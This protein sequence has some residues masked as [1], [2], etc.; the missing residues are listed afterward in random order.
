MNAMATAQRKS[1]SNDLSPTFG[2]LGPAVEYMLDAAQRGV[3][4]WD[5]MRQNPKPMLPRAA[6]SY[7][8]NG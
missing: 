2:L 3:L 1:A 5:V 4:F 7:R 8:A 6:I